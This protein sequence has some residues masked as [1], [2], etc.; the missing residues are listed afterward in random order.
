MAFVSIGQAEDERYPAW[1]QVLTTNPL[2]RPMDFSS[3]HFETDLPFFI[4]DVYPILTSDRQRELLEQPSTMMTDSVTG[5]SS[6]ARESYQ[7]G[8][9]LNGIASNYLLSMEEDPS[10]SQRHFANLPEPPTW[11]TA[12]LEPSVSQALSFPS[13]SL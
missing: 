7:P 11:S 5:S 2:V 4:D 10:E 9:C 12:E 1:P 8:Q 13:Q 6:G 3:S